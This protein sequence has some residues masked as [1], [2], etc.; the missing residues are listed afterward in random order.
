[1]RD[2]AQEIVVFL[3]KEAWDARVS[4][5][6]DQADKLRWSEA[7][8][9]LDGLSAG[10]FAG[11]EEHCNQVRDQAVGFGALLTHGSG[12]TGE[13]CLAPT[14]NRLASA[15]WRKRLTPGPAAVQ[16]RDRQDCEREEQ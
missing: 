10:S 11:D 3:N 13:A 6:R 12:M 4:R 14:D 9:P 5:D 15:K 7:E 2:Q 1:M 8:R 16:Q